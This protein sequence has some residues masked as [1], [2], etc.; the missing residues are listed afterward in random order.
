MQIKIMDFG[1]GLLVG[2]LLC[3]HFL[4]V[5]VQQNL[6]LKSSIYS[7][8]NGDSDTQ[9]SGLLLELNEIMCANEKCM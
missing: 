1:A 7:I 6:S 2:T 3:Y 5:S 8:P 9:S 4:A